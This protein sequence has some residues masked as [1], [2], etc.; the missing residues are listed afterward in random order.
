MNLCIIPAVVRFLISI[1]L[2]F[3]L[4]P[5]YLSAAAESE[6]T[7]SDR[8][9]VVQ[10]I[11]SLKLQDEILTSSM[12]AYSYS[13][14]Q[15]WLERYDEAAKRLSGTIAELRLRLTE[16][17]AEYLDQIVAFDNTLQQ[18]ERLAR[19]YAEKNELEKARSV[20]QSL[21]YKQNKSALMEVIGHLSAQF[22]EAASEAVPDEAPSES[23]RIPLSEEE[24][25]WI[26]LNPVVVGKE[27]DWPPFNF[28]D[29]QGAHVGITIDFL[30][31]IARKTGLVFEFSEPASY[32]DLHKKLKENSIDLIAASYFSEERSSYA[33]HTPSYLVLR[34]FV[35]S[36]ANSGIETME[37]LKGKTL[38]IPSGYATIDIVKE[39][40]PHVIVIEAPSIVKALEMVLSGQADATMDSQSVIEFYLRENALSGLQSFPSTLGSNP[41]RMLISGQKPLLHAILTKAIGSVSAQERIDILSKWLESDQAAKP[42]VN[43]VFAEL[44]SEEQN[45]IVDHPVVKIG[46]D[47]NWAPFE[48]IDENGQYKGIIAD[49]V[50]LIGEQ[51]GIEFKLQ[52]ADSWSDVLDMAKTGVVDVLPGLS[53]TEQRRKE[54][55]FSEP[56]LQ[57]P[58]IVITRKGSLAVG[59]M[60]ELEGQTLGVVENYASTDWAKAQFPG[61]DYVEAASLETALLDVASGKIDAVLANQFSALSLVNEYGLDNLQIAFKTDFK[62][63]LSFAVRQDWPELVPIL[64]KAISAITPAQRDTLRNRW[65]NIDLTSAVPPTVGE[66]AQRLPIIQ[67]VSITL[68]LAVLFVGGIWYLARKSEGALSLYQSSR[69]RLFGMLA[70]SSILVVVLVLTWHSL[71]KEEKIA[72]QRAGQS[73][74]TVLNATHETL[75]YWIKGRLRLV[76]LVAREASLDSLFAERLQHL[77]ASPA[78]K[79][80]STRVDLLLD[81]HGLGAGDWQFSLLLTDGTP[82]FSNTHRADHLMDL[83]RA[84][85]FKGEAVFIPPVIDPVTQ[86]PALYFAA[87]VLDYAGKPIA[88]VVAKSDPGAVFANILRKGQVGVSGE[89][90]AVN[91]QGIMLSESRFAQT[92]I[93]QN[94]L[95]PGDKTLLNLRVSNPASVVSENGFALGAQ[96]LTPAAASLTRGDSN[97]DIEGFTDYRGE[98]VLSAWH[99]DPELGFGLIAEMDESEALAAHN[100]SRNT[101]YALL[102]VTLFLS[103][104]L[105]GI[106]NWIGDRATRSLVRARDE[107]EDKV[108]ERTLEL[109]K[110]KDQF[111]NLLESAPDPMVVSDQS[112]HVIMV[113][114]RA[115]ELFGYPRAELLGQPVEMLVPE[116]F[117]GQHRPQRE[118]FAKAPTVRS[119]GLNKDLFALTKAGTKVPVEISLSPIESESGVLIA[120][121][122]RDI[123]ERKASEKALAESRKLLQTVLDN[124]PALIYMKDLQG[125]YILVNKVW[126]EV[127]NCER[128]LALGR[129]DYELHTP[130]D[131]EFFRENDRQVLSQGETLQLEETLHHADGSTS[132]YISFKFPVFDEEGEVFALGGI[133]S[134]MTE[135]ITAREAAKDANRAKSEFLAN[136]S[137]EIRTPMNAIIGMSYLALQ[138]DLTPRQ[139]DYV[140]KINAA[141]NALLGIINDIL[142]FSKIEAGKLELETIAFNLDETIENLVSLMQV[143][144]QEK[145]LELMVSIDPDVPRGLSGDPLRLG[146]I[147]INL[148]N[149]SVKFTDSGEIVVRIGVDQR[150]QENVTLHYSVSD[151]GIGMTPDQ[152]KNLFQSFSQADASTTRKYG[153]TGLG[154]SICKQLTQMMG[155]EIWVESES[156]QG[157]TFHFTTRMALNADADSLHLE[158][159]PDLRGL[160][161]LIVDDS[162]A[163]RAILKQTAES[164]T[165]EP[166]VA[167]SGPEALEMIAKND[168]RGYPFSIVFVDWRMPRMD[169]I[170]FNEAL[171]SFEGLK[172]PPKVIMITAYDTNEMLRKVGKSVA[173]V[174]SKPV[175]ASSLLDASMLALGRATDSG[176]SKK[177]KQTDEMIAM[178]VSG[179]N[180]LLVEDNE[181]N[182]QVATEL[183]ERA[184]MA[185]E[186]AE[187]GQVAVDKIKTGSY[188]IVLMDLQ[189]PVM[190]GFEAAH[191]IRKEPQFDDLPIVAMTANAMSGD[192]ERCLEAG[193]QDHVAKPI[194][195]VSLYHALVRWIK[196]REGLGDFQPQQA[197]KHGQGDELPLPEID[198]LDTDSGLARLAGNRKLYLELLHRFAKDQ[199]ESS[200]QIAE[201]L[202]TNDFSTSERIAHTVKGVAGTLGATEI[203]NT[204]ALL[205]TMF[206]NQQRDEAEQRL[207]EMENLIAAM[208]TA[209]KAYESQVSSAAANDTEASDPVALEQCQAVMVELKTLLENDDGDAED[210]FL[211]N[212]PLI[213]RVAPDD[214]A[215]ELG[216]HIEN[217]DFEA[218]L[219]VVSLIL[220]ELPATPERPDLSELLLL[221][222]NDDG[223]AADLFE[224]LSDTLSKTLETSVYSAMSDAIE[225]FEFELAAGIVRA[226]I[227][228]PEPDE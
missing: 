124:S 66:A 149:N 197:G 206:K 131:A 205:E 115:E 9:E 39:R 12:T 180:I 174:L 150:D 153:G 15:A 40:Q 17:E 220:S 132:T 37:D 18:L 152:V 135:L 157:S 192:K 41:L 81:Q 108:I 21:D 193:M 175:S 212:R 226:L 31:L 11:E 146:Q 58:T 86:Q 48:F 63:Q 5:I 145:G 72:R 46:A 53:P 22:I 94:I 147:L 136:M 188:D 16:T 99:W 76:T 42:S 156:G 126:E 128:D 214:L 24:R 28:I 199:A 190:D 73:L 67:F 32:A 45:W 127:V 3:T 129:D 110:S 123:T 213:Q 120:T 64:N 98:R 203:Q 134:D 151:T 117:R 10:L 109:S 65:I 6:A 155:G 54:Y 171:R 101:L 133:S 14:E 91:A 88:A 168:E 26:E 116:E 163:A 224:S 89:T 189:M 178:P 221:L 209:I 194:N 33:L 185:V 69:L 7:G 160:P 105:M 84:R 204:A 107:L 198:G 130:E 200:A 103:L 141:A 215:A 78:T 159:D 57:I 97:L 30:Q 191:A 122:L 104:S 8:S 140:N 102:G 201:A 227:S 27:V 195:P 62:Y 125:R 121:S 162:P 79:Q 208:V 207:P 144:V 4:F 166:L 142:D 70:L 56:Y 82:V 1:F 75:K 139:E 223:D 20:L 165:F 111:M 202:K 93:E 25:A 74:V 59:H 211:D 85:V 90:Y 34:E 182:Q 181:I 228:D 68:G 96:G 118:R 222:E 92:L 138:S 119:M 217:F 158:P 55:N 154:L 114:N 164:L 179:A 173:G 87:P 216:E 112:G 50:S 170:Q 172:S 51:L 161:V 177:E 169:G 38:V 44:N 47:P 183:L 19:D 196:P 23:E 49:Y 167:S 80:F 61:I 77:G 137:H 13:R 113:N 2:C 83:L 184:G 52:P 225:Q 60:A 100:I 219:Q 29:R 186:I 148:V 143:K 218:A 36:R 71:S 210:C 43:A 106:N 35:Y 95:R 176:S 187:N